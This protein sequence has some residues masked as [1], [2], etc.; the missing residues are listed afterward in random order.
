VNTNNLMAMAF[1]PSLILKAR[2]FDT[3]PWQRDVLL[4]QDR[5]ILLNCCRQ[6]GKSTVTSALALHTALFKPKSDVLLLSPGQ[7]QSQEIFR[8]VLEPTTP[9]AGPS[10]APM[11][12]SSA[13]SSP[14]AAAS[15][16]CLPGKEATIRGY[17]PILIIIDEASR[18]PSTP[19]DQ[20]GWFF[21]GVRRFSAAFFLSFFW[22]DSGENG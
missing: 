8:K 10:A 17:T 2:G 11:K 5:E 16:A 4:A 14:T 21:F 3:D 9:S 13:W 18:V 15:C 12:R 1:A 22:V 6:A 19:F 20:R 7:R